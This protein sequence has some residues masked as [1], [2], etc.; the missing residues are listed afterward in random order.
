[1][2]MAYRE[3]QTKMRANGIG[4]TKEISSVIDVP[5][6]TV[7]LADGALLPIDLLFPLALG[8]RA[9]GSTGRF[10]PMDEFDFEPDM[11][12]SN[13]LRYWAWREDEIKFVGAL[14]AREVS[15]RYVKTLGTI[16][17]G[18]SPILILNCE[19]WL[20]MRTAIIAA[21]SIGGN[22]TR[23]AALATDLPTVEFEFLASAI[24]RK[25]GTPVRR[26]RTRYRRD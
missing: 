22:P 3:L 20:E 2:N 5:I 17:A 8:E 9:D 16:T 12:Q 18:N 26:Q 6:G 21:K 19:S 14:T 7:R 23:A 4:V 15:I 10:T 13:E 24:K 11:A 25:Q 1:M